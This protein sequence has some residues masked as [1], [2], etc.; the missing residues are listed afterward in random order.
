MRETNDA[1]GVVCDGMRQR[2]HSI[3]L[4][5]VTCSPIFQH[6]ACVTCV[7]MRAYLCVHVHICA[8]A[9]VRTCICVFVHV[10]VFVCVCV[11]E[12]RRQE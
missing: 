3:S 7:H 5:P 1:V 8:L 9:C 6:P 10:C 4:L 2:P 12:S 11:Q